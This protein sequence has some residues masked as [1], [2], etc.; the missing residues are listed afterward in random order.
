MCVCVCV[1]ARAGAGARERERERVY[2]TL[3]SASLFIWYA[4]CIVTYS[5]K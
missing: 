2:N 5:Y 3:I 4:L 1:C